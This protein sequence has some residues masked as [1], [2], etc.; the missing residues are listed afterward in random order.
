MGVVDL[1]KTVFLQ[2]DL[3]VVGNS[4]ALGSAAY[5]PAALRRL[6]LLQAL[7]KQAATSI[8]LHLLMAQA[9]H[10]APAFPPHP[11]TACVPTE[12]GDACIL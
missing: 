5:Q 10:L 8:F 1:Q 9:L 3:M 12:S 2:D 11:I 7:A 6:P 4:L